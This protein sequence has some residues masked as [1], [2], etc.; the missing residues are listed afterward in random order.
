MPTK[1]VASAPGKVILFGEHAV[2]YGRPAIAVPVTQVQAI[3]E[4]ELTRHPLQL[5]AVDLRRQ[6]ALADAPAEDPLATAVRLTLDH[7][8]AGPPAARLTVRSTI[9]I[10]SGM[11]SGAAVSVAII[12]AV[13]EYLGHTLTDDEVCRLAFQV[14][15]LYH[16][17]PSG[18]DNT[19]VTYSRPVYFCHGQPM[20][21]LAVPQA[22]LILVAVTGIASPTRHVVG[23][24]RRAWQADPKRFE[25]IFDQV[26]Q[27]AESAR[28][29][30]EEGRPGELGP[31][32]ERNQ[33]LLTDMGVSSPALDRL[34]RVALAAGAEG[35]KLSGA[36][37][38]GNL[39]ALVRPETEA[40]VS[41][42]LLEAGAAEV[43]ATWV[44][45]S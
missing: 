1:T 4:M 42:A 11:G 13:S 25:A 7:L 9:P 24:V 21:T 31:L 35:A 6:W 38:G 34:I 32:M 22:F 16:G 43:I 29:A 17:T 30:I 19:V 39:L 28:T 2:V 20:R 5:D 36:G 45:E 37:R 15:K 10:A 14:E 27:V 41:Q 44:R 40:A 26:G 3:A 12:R 18:I 8:G 23:D 33:A